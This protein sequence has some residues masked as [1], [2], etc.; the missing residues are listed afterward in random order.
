M[1]D[2]NIIMAGHYEDAYPPWMLGEYYNSIQLIKIDTSINP[3]WER[4]FGFDAN[5]TPIY[6]KT[7][8]DGGFLILSTRYDYQ[9]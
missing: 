8:S 5:Y 4:R 1:F 2:G 9:T 7:L 6:I 3:I